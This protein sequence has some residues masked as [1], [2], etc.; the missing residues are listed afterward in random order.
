MKK[1]I[2]PS[3]QTVKIETKE[4]IA[5]LPQGVTYENGVTTYNLNTYYAASTIS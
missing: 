2:I 4:N 5:A 1:Y 3:L